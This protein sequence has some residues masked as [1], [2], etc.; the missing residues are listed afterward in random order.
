M[1]RIT[2]AAFFLLLAGITS[3][4]TL[5]VPSVQGPLQIDGIGNEEMWKQAVVLPIGRADFDGPFPGGGEMRA[6]IR[7]D[8]LCLSAHLPETGRVVARSTGRNPVWW[9]EDLVNWSLH[10]RSFSTYLTI[11]VN[12]L[13]GY[14]VESTGFKADPQSVLA[15]AALASDGWSAEVAIPTK[16]IASLLSISVERIR[17]P[18]PNA[19]ELRW[20]WPGLNDRL[21]LELAQGAADVASPSV[22]VKDWSAHVRPSGTAKS[23]DAAASELAAV[24][25]HVW[26]DAER[27]RL[28]VDTMWERNL[29]ARVNDSALRERRDWEKVRTVSDWEAFRNRRISAL[30]A[31]LGA[32][33]DRTPLRA[34][35][36]R[37]LDY[38]DGFVV[39]DVLFESRPGLVVT[40]NLYLP[41]KISARIP[42]I[43]VVHSHHFPKVQSELQDLG[44][45]WARSGT[46][47][48]IMDQLGA[49]ER[50]QSQPWLREGYYA[51][52]ALGMQLYL[53]GDSLMKWMVWDLMRGIDLLLERPYVDPKR[54]VMLGAVAGGGDPAAV[55]AALDHRIAAVLPFNF[56]EAGPEE[57]YTMGPRPYDNET[58]NPGW[59]EWESTRCLRDSIA[60]QFFP[61]MICAA[62]APRPFVFSF[63]LSW[64]NG[65]EQEPIW[66]RYKKVFELYGKPDHLAEIDGFGSFPGP[67]EVED[68]GVNHRKKIYPILHR[69]LDVPIPAEEYHNVR[70]DADFMSLTPEAAA[71]RKPK[72]ASE[73]A[74]D[75]AKS[76]LSAAREKRAKLSVAERLASLRASLKTKLGDIEPDKSASGA[77]LWTKPSTSFTAEG[78]ALETQPGMTVPVLL[79]KPRAAGAQRAPVVLGF[80]QNGKEAFLSD[81]AAEVAALLK[82]GVALCLVD[83]RGS[84]ESASITPPGPTLTSLSATELML[85]NTALGG[86]LKDARTVVH[87]LSSR[88][89]LDA[90]RLAVWGD[91]FAEVNSEEFLLDQSLKQQPGP[92]LIHEAEPMGSFLAVL[93]AL[94]EDNVRAVAARGGLVSYLSVLE[95]RFCYVPEDI[96]VPGILETADIPDLIAAI[97]PRA[98]LIDS[99]V[100]G[101]DRPLS[102]SEMQAQLQ[103]VIANPG[104]MPQLAVR[105]RG[106]KPEL[107]EWIASHL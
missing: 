57:H 25:R 49:G 26:S 4:K 33:P 53:P 17:A 39:E 56:G 89:D 65:V 50:I 3:A 59:G 95:D 23:S 82:K 58:A 67:G 37:R 102:A 96:I 74:L 61:W 18:R 83:V 63:E 1:S 98:E 88:S 78:I 99:A 91:S 75:I 5:K 62:A 36:T 46:A 97:A 42:A 68:V 22:V 12:P 66:K 34:A 7:G 103:P 6:A 55:T 8:Y 32:F 69:W 44:M 24:P 38:G 104:S 101:R 94:Y 90:K 72:T 10:F 85:G 80:A 29:Q 54:I 40:A 81:R 105:D 60:G 13:G 107:A 93:T 31:S 35:V 51:R 71:E 21:G 9:N 14:H 2:V 87:Y 73:I 43:V 45:T 27:K 47:V 79:L 19:P 76:R 77:V 41:S 84:G 28:E 48:L 86:R 15:S 52:Y 100:D 64:P 92:Q 106:A 30:K 20:Y 16:I 11:S 70:P